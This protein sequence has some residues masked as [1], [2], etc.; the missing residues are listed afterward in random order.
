MAEKK[1]PEAPAKTAKKRAP[2][3]KAAKPVEAPEPAGEEISRVDL[4]RLA[5]VEHASPHSFLGAHPA[6]LNGEQGAIV[7]AAVA[8]ADG[9]D[10]LLKDGTVVPMERIASGLVAVYQAFLPG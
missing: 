1:K 4:E 3:K 8:N 5:G 6:T 9:A 7:R 10:V 2:R